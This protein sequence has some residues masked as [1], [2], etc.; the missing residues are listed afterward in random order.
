MLSVGPDGD[1]APPGKGLRYARPERE[2]RFL[3]GRPPPGPCI[4][5]AEISD[6]YVAGTRLRVRRAEETTTTGR[7]VVYKLT[8]KIPAANGAPGRITTIYLSE[9]EHAR[10]RKLPG[11]E[12]RKLRYSVPP[13]GV[14]VFGG[15][16][17]GLLLA[18]AEFETPE[19]ESAF[20]PPDVAVAEVTG[21][22]RF[23]GGRLIGTRR[24]ALL[25]LLEEFGLRPVDASELAGRRLSPPG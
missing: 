1:P 2:R 21:D 6:L 19:E 17:A 9:E 7:Q 25:T 4:R 5:R 14:D 22:V 11:E 10:V 20:P 16:L 3:L 23:T 12:L 18:E 15:E 13:F 24:P 8:Q